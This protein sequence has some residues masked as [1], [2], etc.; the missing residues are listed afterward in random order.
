MNSKIYINNKQ[1]EFLDNNFN[2]YENLKTDELIELLEDYM[3]ENTSINKTDD[4]MILIEEI[5]DQLS[6]IETENFEIENI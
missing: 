2:K 4:T 1:K 5:I 6:E 3:Q